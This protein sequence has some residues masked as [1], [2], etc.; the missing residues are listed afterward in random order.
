[1]KVRRKPPRNSETDVPVLRRAAWDAAVS[2]GALRFIDYDLLA[3]SAETYQ[4]QD[5]MMGAMA[6]ILILSRFFS[7]RENVFPL[8]DRRRR[9]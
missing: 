4:R 8:F 1:V 5:H 6:R 7:I 2:S 9:S 3:G